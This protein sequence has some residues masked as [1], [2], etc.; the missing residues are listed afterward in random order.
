MAG[1]APSLQLDR[2]LQNNAFESWRL[3]GS[4]VHRRTSAALPAP[5]A[6][7]AANGSATDFLHTRERV[8]HNHLLHSQGR[9][10]VCCIP[11]SNAADGK[12]LA[13]LEV[14]ASASADDDEHAARPELRHVAGRLACHSC[15]GRSTF[16]E[17]C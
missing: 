5:V 2:S 11:D 7:A 13:L 16:V 12:T 8:L 3:G 4:F 15:S 1:S 6:T 10:F 9:L 17:T 14:L